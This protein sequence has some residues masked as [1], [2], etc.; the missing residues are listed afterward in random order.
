MNK[1][2]EKLQAKHDRALAAMDKKRQRDWSK[3]LG[4]F[5]KLGPLVQKLLDL[6]AAGKTTQAEKVAQK[7]EK[8]TSTQPFLKS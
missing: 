6:L 3:W 7:L 8:L 4:L 1:A 2:A 5:S